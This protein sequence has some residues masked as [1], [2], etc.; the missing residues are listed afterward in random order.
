METLTACPTKTATMLAC[1][2]IAR[3]FKE[4]IFELSRIRRDW[5]LEYATSL[6]VW[7]DDTI[8]KHYPDSMQT[9]QNINYRSWHEL[10]ISGMQYLKILRASIKVDFK[11]DPAFQREFFTRVGY[12]LYFSDAKSGDH[13]S[14]Y[15]FLKTFASNLDEESRSK[16]VKKGT[17]DELFDKILMCANQIDEFEDCFITLEEDKDINNYGK[18]EIREIYES[19]KDICKIAS[20]YYQ[21]DPE[22]RC[23][24]NL[25]KVLVNL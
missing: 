20:A 3:T 10:M 12:S 1:Q 11:D 4:N 18:K 16:I 6:N 17:M 24:F 25:Y 21:F 2:K 14:L 15:H 13:I 5:D 9:L 8:E 7:I 19:T 23:R 22:M